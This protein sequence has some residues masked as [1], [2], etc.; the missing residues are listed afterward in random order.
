MDVKEAKDAYDRARTALEQAR[1]NTPWWN[2][3]L[4]IVKRT[5]G[6]IPMDPALFEAWKQDNQ[7]E[8]RLNMLIVSY[9]AQ[10]QEEE[11]KAL[12]HLNTLQK[13]K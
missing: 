1:M 11:V 9:T 3:Y 6:P 4:R 12:R 8:I 7:D 5:S 2:T 10:A 13:L